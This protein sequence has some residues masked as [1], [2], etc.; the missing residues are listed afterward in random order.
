MDVGWFAGRA[1]IGCEAK[2]SDEGGCC[3]RNIEAGADRIAGSELRTIRF[4]QHFA[5]DLD[6]HVALEFVNGVEVYFH[7]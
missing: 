3:H 4:E 7:A 2:G 5:D 6:F 1:E